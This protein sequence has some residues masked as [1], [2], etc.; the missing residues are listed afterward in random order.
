MIF[1]FHP[2]YTVGTGVSPVHAFLLA[3][4][5]AGGEFHP[6]LKNICAVAEFSVVSCR[7]EVK[8][9]AHSEKRIIL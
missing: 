1:F 7:A 4:Y 6:A 9:I 2:D 8:M 5:T 3:D